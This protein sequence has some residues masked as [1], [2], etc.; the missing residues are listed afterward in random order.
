MLLLDRLEDLGLGMELLV[1][2]LE[3]VL[4]VM[5]VDMFQRLCAAAA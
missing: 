1:L 3:L 2:L 4:K 5:L